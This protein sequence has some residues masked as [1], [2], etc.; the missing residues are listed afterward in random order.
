[1][2]KSPEEQLNEKEN[3]NETKLKKEKDNFNDGDKS[4]EENNLSNFIKKYG[5]E[6]GLPDLKM[7]EN[8]ICSLCFRG[9]INVDIVYNENNM[10]CFFASPICYIPNK[11]VEKFYEQLLISN[12]NYNKSGGVVLGI[13]EET[14]R[15]ILSYT[16]IAETFSYILFR[17]ALLNFV[18]IT[19]ANMLKFEE[20]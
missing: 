11:N 18:D 10:D 9:K 3:N 20:F 1:M 2:E 13:Q 16:F 7:N 19:E 5:K 6:I 15:V 12:N 8:N 17:N 14:N 4:N